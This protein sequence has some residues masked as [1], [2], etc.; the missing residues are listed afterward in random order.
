[1]PPVWLMDEYAAFL[2][3]GRATA[4]VIGSM[5]LPSGTDSLNIPKLATGSST[6]IQTADGGSVSSTD[7]TDSTVAAPVQ[8][9]AGQQDIAIQLLEQSPRSFDEIIFKDL[10]ADLNQKTDQQVLYGTGASGEVKGIL[11]VT[12]GTTTATFT[13]TTAASLYSKIAGLINSVH[14]S[15]FLPPDAIIMHPRRWAFLLAASDSNGRPLVLP[16]AQVPQNAMGTFQG[17]ASQGAVGSLQGVDVFVDP[18]VPTN[19]GASTGE[20]RVI[21]IRRS[22]PLF[23]EG[24]LNTRVLPDVLSANLKIR[25]QVYRYIAFTAE[26]YPQSI[27][28]LQGTGLNGP[29]F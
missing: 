5:A 25:L 27:A 9:I 8:T 15:R 14:T 13:G 2:R 6:A 19:L 11:T 10:I 23:W 7:V 12:T 3:A 29:V 26:R 28:T 21:V 22:D 17:P 18:N 1:M 16:N 20:D 24:A 4:E